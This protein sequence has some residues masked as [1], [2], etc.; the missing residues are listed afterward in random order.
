MLDLGFPNIP[1]HRAGTNDV[2][3]NS[4][5]D[6]RNPKAKGAHAYTWTFWHH[7]SQNESFGLIS[8]VKSDGR[9]RVVFVC[10]DYTWEFV[11]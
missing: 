6:R 5:F 1:F 7:V 4:F 3:F 11:G 8:D 10:V 2:V 9:E